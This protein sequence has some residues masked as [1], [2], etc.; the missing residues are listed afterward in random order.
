MTSTPIQAEL[1]AVDRALRDAGRDIDGFDGAHREALRRKL[2][3]LCKRLAAVPP[4]RGVRAA[5]IALNNLAVSLRREASRELLA[6]EIEAA[7][8][9]VAELLEVR[10]LGVSPTE[11]RRR[12]DDALLARGI[13]ACL[14]C[15]DP[16]IEVELG[17]ALFR[18]YPSDPRIPPSQIPS[19]VLSCRAC[20]FSWTHNLKRLGIL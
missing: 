1:A 8:E 9:G 2:E 10:D 6:D 13:T 18:P 7:I 16:D 14:A 19:A 4:A 17:Y 3:R 20:G 11:L 15:S 12:V 5:S